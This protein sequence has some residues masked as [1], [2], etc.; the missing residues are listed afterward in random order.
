M[1]KHYSASSVGT[2]MQV[3]SCVPAAKHSEPGPFRVGPLNVYVLRFGRRGIYSL[4]AEVY[5]DRL[6]ATYLP[7][8]K[9]D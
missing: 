4:L 7:S 9:V 3:V 5:R 6:L 2:D 1:T 8:S